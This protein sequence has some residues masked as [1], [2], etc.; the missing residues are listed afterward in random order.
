MATRGIME[1]VRPKK[2]LGQH[3]LTDRNIAEK[4]VRSLT[5]SQTRCVAEVGPGMGI[6]SQFLLADDRIDA[7]FVEI[8]EESVAYLLGRFPAM[9]G[10]ILQQDFLQC[11]VSRLFGSPVAVI[12]NFPYNISSPI[13][14][15]I[16][17]YRQWVPEVVCMVQKEVAQR[18][19]EPPGSKLYGILSVLLQ[20]YYHIDYLFT[21]NEQVFSPPPKVKSAVI[22]LERNDVQSLPCD[23]ELFFRVVKTA[24]NQRRK[25]LSNSL[26][27]LLN[28]AKPAEEIFRKRP[29]QLSVQDFVR[30]VNYGYFT[31]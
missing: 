17:A 13:F 26:K 24:F 28:G 4:I 8:D 10:R 31:S 16:L 20:A 11:D 12:G 5:L 3:F 15:R 6:L 22:R 9:E 2:S 21:V 18:I 30:L 7:R 27:N 1:G 14:F 19:A 25:T 29:E 23:E